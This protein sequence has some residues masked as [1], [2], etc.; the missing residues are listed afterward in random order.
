MR[1]IKFRA[2]DK[3]QKEMIF[4]GVDFHIRLLQMTD[5][6]KGERES[7]IG[8]QNEFEGQLFE[9]MQFT[10]LHDKNGK[11]IYEGDIVTVGEFEEPIIKEV[12]YVYYAFSLEKHDVYMPASIILKVIGNIHENPE[13]LEAVK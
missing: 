10:G 5:E 8:F 1:E 11:E 13:L 3:K 4:S 7:I 2:W 9:M 12:S 6:Y